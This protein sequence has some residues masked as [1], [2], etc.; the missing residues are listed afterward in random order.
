MSLVDTKFS[1]IKMAMLVCLL[2]FC[3]P[4]AQAEQQ[5][6]CSTPARR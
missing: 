2:F 5:I 4:F 3:T 1:E 6:G